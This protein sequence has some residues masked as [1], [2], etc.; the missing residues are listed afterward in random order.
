ISKDET[1]LPSPA[2]LR[3]KIILKHKKLPNENEI[4]TVQRSDDDD[5]DILS[6]DCVKRG[7]LSLRNNTDYEWTKHVFVLFADRLCYVA[8]PV[9]DVN[10]NSKE[11]TL[12]QLGEED[13]DDESSLI[14]FGVRPEEMHVT[15]EWFH[16]KIDVDT[17]KARLLEQAEKGNGVFLVRESGTFIGEYTLSFLHEKKV[18]HVRIKTSMVNGKK[19]YYF[20]KTTS[21]DT[22]YELISYYTK[23]SIATEKFRTRLITPCPQPQPHLNQPWFSD[24]ADKQRAEEL[25]NTV[26]ED[27]A[28]LIRYSSSDPSVFV[29]CLRADGE[30]YHFRLKRDGRI[31]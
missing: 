9:E 31:F 23:H 1:H 16:G 25:L 2:A 5:P 29:L 27:G 6:K 14:G 22:L 3:K 30:L 8:A 26:H 11:D 15:E 13:R 28:F 19:Q 10:G 4:L 21:M 17:A 20:F 12:S 7:V 18:H 24:K